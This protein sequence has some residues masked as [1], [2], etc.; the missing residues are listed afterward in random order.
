M[1]H[2]W[3]FDGIG[4]FYAELRVV[5]HLV[6]LKTIDLCVVF[7]VKIMTWVWLYGSQF[8]Y[9]MHHSLLSRARVT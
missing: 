8:H 6:L 3:R 2:K 4:P 1:L 9:A 7:V 5:A